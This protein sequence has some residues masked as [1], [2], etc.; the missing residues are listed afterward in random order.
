[1]VF[2]DGGCV[3]GGDSV[4]KIPLRNRKGSIAAWALVDDQD[5][6]RAMA[7][8]WH[9][10]RTKGLRY[11]CR[12]LR[13]TE[14]HRGTEYL[15]RFI[16]RAPDRKM[17]IDHIDGNGLNNQRD[18]LRA[19]TQ[20]NNLRNCKRR[21]DNAAGFKGIHFDKSKNKWTAKLVIK[22]AEI[23]QERFDTLDAAKAAYV[24]AANK[25]HGQFTRGAKG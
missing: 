8:K 2:D 7:H 1:M 18:N 24:A 21:I 20:S 4:K 17:V 10:F 3:A 25:Y 12:N 19:C 13:R 11:A 9:M 16:L 14:G 6:D 5:Y 15:H 22:P 23:W